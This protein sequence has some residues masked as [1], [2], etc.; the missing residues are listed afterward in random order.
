MRLRK[1]IAFLLA[2]YSLDGK[3]SS[4]CIWLKA[5]F[6]CEKGIKRGI[7]TFIRA[8]LLELPFPIRN[9]SLAMGG[10]NIEYDTWRIIK[11]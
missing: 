8:S 11:S 4:A 1:K 3:D 10:K 6:E 9:A 2:L 7:T 5:L